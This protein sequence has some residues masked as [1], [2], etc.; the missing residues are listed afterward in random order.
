MVFWFVTAAVLLILEL[1][2]GTVY[3]LVVSAALFG[4]GFAAWL[5]DSFT[6]GV[7]TAAVLSAL[8]IWWVNG[9]IRRHRRPKQEEDALHDLD[10][11]QTVQVIRHMY[12]DIYEVLY[13][14]ALWQAKA[15][16]AES[17]REAVTAVVTGKGGNVLFIHLH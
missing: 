16:N 1:F 3:L 11:G 17:G 6:A 4:A 5:F 15:D 14:G 10:V 7:L 8:G 9:W 12:D 13:R 2:I